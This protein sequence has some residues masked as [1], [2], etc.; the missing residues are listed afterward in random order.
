M[1]THFFT[2][3]TVLLRRYY[4]LFV[5]E[6]QRRVVHLLDVTASPNEPW[7]TQVA[8]N[9]VAD[10]EE[11][12]RHFWFPLRDR[13]TKFTASFD[14]LFASIGIEAVKS[15]VRSPQANWPSPRQPD[16]WLCG[17]KTTTGVA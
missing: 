4:V 13:D 16:T 2:V 12:G 5:V 14:A 7:V 8:R 3:D 6:V 9:L 15:P 10:L 1:A 17:L 11:A